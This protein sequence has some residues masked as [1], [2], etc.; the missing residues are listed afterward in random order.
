MA[1]VRWVVHAAT[2]K[3]HSE[4]HLRILAYL[5]VLQAL[6]Q[7]YLVAGVSLHTVAQEFN[8][9]GKEFVQKYWDAHTR[10]CKAPPTLFVFALSCIYELSVSVVDEKGLRTDGFIDGTKWR[11]KLKDK[12]W[13]VWCRKQ[14][15]DFID[16]DISATLPFDVDSSASEPESEHVAGGGRTVKQPR[17]GKWAR[18]LRRRLKDDKV[19]RTVTVHVV[20][21]KDLQ[22]TYH[23]L[24]GAYIHSG[25]TGEVRACQE[26]GQDTSRT[27]G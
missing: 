17:L 24:C 14:D 27:E 11:L 5:W 26:G 22:V 19:L 16:F 25:N 7:H 4:E 3:T 2:G 12:R 23:N 18:A 8:M 10:K 13:Q 20:R 21:G 15:L 6:K 1:S 9:T